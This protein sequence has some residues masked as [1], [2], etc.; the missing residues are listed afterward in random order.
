MSLFVSVPQAPGACWSTSKA[1][2][3]SLLASSVCSSEPFWSNNRTEQSAL[4]L[5]T[6]PNGAVAPSLLTTSCCCLDGLARVVAEFSSQRCHWSQ[7]LA[8]GQDVALL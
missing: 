8:D 5:A 4:A 7:R 3:W 6:T 2:V 1:S